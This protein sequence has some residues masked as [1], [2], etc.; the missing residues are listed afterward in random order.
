MLLEKER[1]L[2]KE[3]KNQRKKMRRSV[4][5]KRDIKKGNVIKLTDLDLKRPGTGISADK[6]SKI[7]GRKAKRNIIKNYLLKYSDIQ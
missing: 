2:S 5:A 4:V 3:E 1:K 7:I 6:I